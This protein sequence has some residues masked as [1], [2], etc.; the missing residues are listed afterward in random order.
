[1]SMVLLHMFCHSSKNNVMRLN[2]LLRWQKYFPTGRSNDLKQ[3]FIWAFCCI[4]QKICLISPSKC[5][6]AYQRCALLLLTNSQAHSA[7]STNVSSIHSCLG[8]GSF[9]EQ[10]TD[11]LGMVLAGFTSYTPCMIDF[12]G[13][14]GIFSSIHLIC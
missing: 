1:M 10:Q 8:P 12:L 4:S 6:T 11:C 13:R 3:R 7:S 5:H 2:L 9:H 14:F